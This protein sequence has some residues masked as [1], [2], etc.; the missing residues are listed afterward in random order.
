MYTGAGDQN[1]I[2]K[3]QSN[4]PGG[5]WKIDM[6]R[7]RVVC[8]YKGADGRAAVRSAQ[9]LWDNSW[10][11]V[12]CARRATGVTLTVDNG[13]PRTNA[14]KTGNIANTWELAIGGKSRCDPP[15]I[16]CDYYVG[17]LDYARIEK[18]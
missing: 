4:T 13:T 17:R 12:R 6:V 10:H 14:G 1:I 15:T 5:M 9:T 16:Q 3:G 8:M 2:Q 11:V 7:G 18:L